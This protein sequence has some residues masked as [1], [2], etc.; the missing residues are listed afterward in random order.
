MM[1]DSTLHQVNL[2]IFIVANSIM[3]AQYKYARISPD[4]PSWRIRLM[5]PATA[6][7]VVILSL[8]AVSAIELMNGAEFDFFMLTF[9]LFIGFIHW[10]AKDGM[11]EGAR[12]S[13]PSLDPALSWWVNRQGHVYPHLM[14]GKEK[15]PA[16]SPS[17]EAADL[18]LGQF[19]TVG[20]QIDKPINVRSPF[21]LAYLI[22]KLTNQGW[23]VEPFPSTRT[24]FSMR[25]ILVLRRRTAGCSFKDLCLGCRKN[26]PFAW[27]AQWQ[28]CAML[29][30]A[31][32]YPPIMSRE[33]VLS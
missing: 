4:A 12:L 19:L 22:K 11:V 18:L 3:L 27:R 23:H 33:V 17:K 10:L 24:P 26:A 8:L 5:S 1:F 13:L 16:L 25:I 30:S 21:K 14:S 7:P 28:Q 9:L 6:Y 20:T 15:V 31:I 2:A 29:H 32:F